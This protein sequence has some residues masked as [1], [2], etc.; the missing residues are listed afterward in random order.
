MTYKI[1]GFIEKMFLAYSVLL[2]AYIHTKCV[3]LS[4]QKTQDSAYSY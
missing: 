2:S 3:S 4:N 1:S